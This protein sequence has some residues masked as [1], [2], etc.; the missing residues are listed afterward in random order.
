MALELRT[1]P[2]FRT[3]PVADAIRIPLSPLDQR[4]SVSVTEPLV[5]SP[6][7]ITSTAVCTKARIVP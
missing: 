2:K 4:A 6:P 5:T 1:V 7:P 3:V